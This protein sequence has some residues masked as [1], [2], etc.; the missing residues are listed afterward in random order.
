MRILWIIIVLL[1]AAV[2]FGQYDAN[3][4]ET[5]D[6]NNSVSGE[7]LDVVEVESPNT[8]QEYI[9]GDAFNLSFTRLLKEYVDAHGLVN[10]PK[11]RRFRLE[12]NNVVEKFANLKPEVYIT[13]SQNEK[14][15]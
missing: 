9:S 1:L 7:L 15:A 4:T 2:C 11:L 14:I 5:G 3:Q 8:P 13:W 6:N 10:Y 12:L